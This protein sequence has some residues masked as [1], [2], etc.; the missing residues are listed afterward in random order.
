MS[1]LEALPVRLIDRVS[2]EDA[3][4]LTNVLLQDEALGMLLEQFWSGGVDGVMLDPREFVFRLQLLMEATQ[5]R[6]FH[7]RHEPEWLR[8][9]DEGEGA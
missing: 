4:K 2:Y 8:R 6:V 1:K 9:D 7:P 5:E 3:E